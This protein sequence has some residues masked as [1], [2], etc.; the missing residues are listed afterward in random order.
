[1]RETGHITPLPNSITSFNRA[2]YHSL[3]NIFLDCGGTADG[4]AR[5]SRLMWDTMLAHYARVFA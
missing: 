4:S 2:L 1:M 3:A 5:Q